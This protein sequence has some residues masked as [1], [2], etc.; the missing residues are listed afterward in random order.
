MT[1]GAGSDDAG[2][3]DAVSHDAA[4]H[5]PGRRA[6]DLAYLPHVDG[7]RAV[8]VIAAVLFH[9][10]LLCP[11]GY[12]GVDVFFVLSGFL[13]TRQIAAELDAGDFSFARFWA[14]RIRRI[15]PASL[16]M[17]AA[18]LAAGWLLLLPQD[19]RLLANDATAH[20]AMLANVR[21]RVRTDYFAAAAELRP[22]LHTWSLA[23][24]EQFYLVLPL[25]LAAGWRLGRRACTGL[26]A[27]LAA[28]SL[29]VAWHR[30]PIDPKAAFYLLPSRGFELLCGSLVALVRWP[31]LPAGAA[32]EA[33]AAAGL[34]AILAP[35]LAYDRQ[36]PFPALAALP[37]CLGT[38]L[39]LL[40]TM[41]PGE[42]AVGRVLA[43]RPLA[44][45]GLVSYSLYLWHW[46]VLAF[47]RYFLGPVIPP[48]WLALAAVPV[49][50]LTFLSW[51]FVET[52]CRRVPVASAPRRVILAAAAV[53]AVM[54]GLCLVVRQAD[55]VP[56]RFAPAVLGM[57]EPYCTD[58]EFAGRRAG[59]GSTFRAI[60]AR[61][62]DDCVCFL[63][64]GDS[65]GMAVSPAID[66]A[67]RA[68][69]VTGA[70]ALQVAAPPVPGVW[71]PWG[72]HAL[73]GRSESQAWVER[74]VRW[75]RRCR[76]RHLVLCARWSMYVSDADP[77][78]RGTHLLAPLDAGLP[79]PEGAR[80]ALRSGLGRLL[81][82]CAETGTDLWVVLE[83][84]HQPTTPQSRALA[85]HWSGRP[86]D[87]AGVTRA[88]HERAQRPVAEALA[89]LTDDRLHLIDLAAPFFDAEGVS[90]VGREGASWYADA[91]HVSPTGARE[92]LEPLFRE[93]FARIAADCGPPEKD[94]D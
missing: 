59:G 53:A 67:A 4:G 29:A 15:W 61:T 3:H 49:A 40:A 33:V 90:R 91:T 17:T 54:A 69:G 7:L 26:V 84:P 21:Y 89:S 13:V 32:R 6:A 5:G 70:A 88:E 12:V 2:S 30:L 36:T 68:R 87:L 56:R 20:L 81:A 27:A 10:G 76:P 9:A 47:L 78:K 64:W 60:G 63:L 38:G 42:S 55:G 62:A 16:V 11:G 65:H 73:A 37:P 94:D 92:A 50:A 86:P 44:A 48:P 23:V 74:I 80:T 77:E 34:A 41:P 25:L 28:V 18:V 71:Q 39:V 93:I 22:L 8:A 35:C 66:A 79:S 43:A 83:P 72:Q 1:H 24:E 58:W 75:M 31:A 51:R 46:P 19:L 85:A 52:P 57:L 82:I 45:V 14:R